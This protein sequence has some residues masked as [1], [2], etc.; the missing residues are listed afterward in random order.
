VATL[1]LLL[2]LLLQGASAIQPNATQTIT[3]NSG[4]N[5]ISIQVGTAPLPVASFQ[6]ALSDPSRLI[7]MWGY[8][9]TGNP[10][11]PGVWRTFQP[12]T[13]AFPSDLSTLELGRGYWVNVSQTTTLTLI[14]IPWDGSVSLVKGWNLVGFPGLSLGATEVIDLSAVFGTGFDRIQQVWTFD[15]AGQRFTGYDLTAIPAL[16]ELASIRPGVGYWV[17]SIA[18]TALVLQPAPFVALPS[19]SDA[20]PPQTA[21]IF[22]ATNP[23]WLG[24]NPTRY[25]GRQIRFRATDGTDTAYDL[26]ANGILDDAETQDTILFEKTGDTVS[27]TI[28]NKGSG[29]LNWSLENNVPWLFTAPGDDR[30]WPTGATTRPSTAAGTVSSEKDTLLLYGPS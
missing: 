24:S 9:P 16:R 28:G 12:A 6:A 10:N 5:L 29:V 19:D 27:I 1:A 17:Y 3:L 11:T 21:E 30:T 2:G 4:W 20:S 22:Q 18:D 25:V 23:R 7:E 13:P 14:G 26:N 15:A 8:D